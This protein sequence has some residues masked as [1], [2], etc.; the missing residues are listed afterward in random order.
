MTAPTR[1]YW[2]TFTYLD[3]R[4]EMD[5]IY[6]APPRRGPRGWKT[7]QLRR[8]KADAKAIRCT[9]GVTR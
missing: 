1:R 2:S 4:D 9:T 5:D 6:D 3:L 7:W 8:I